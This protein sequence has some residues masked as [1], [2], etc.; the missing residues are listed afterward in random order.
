MES[1]NTVNASPFHGDMGLS[2]G[3]IM[4]EMRGQSREA[5]ITQ[6]SRQFE[7]IFVR[8]F[9]E[10]SMKPMIEGALNE[11]GAANDIYRSQVIDALA[12]SMSQ[13]EVFGLS[14]HLREQLMNGTSNASE[15]INKHIRDE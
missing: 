11:S 4:S 10:K 6:A 9:L 13:Q 8:Q 5:Q 14:Q 15:P 12:N 7:A 2:T 3:K 1:I